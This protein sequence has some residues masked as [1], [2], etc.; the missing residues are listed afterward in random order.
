[1]M[2]AADQKKPEFFI[3][4]PGL[5]RASRPTSSLASGCG[6]SRGDGCSAPPEIGE[7]KEMTHLPRALFATGLKNAHAMEN[8]A[9]SI[10]KPQLRRIEF[11]P[12]VAEKLEEHIRETEGQ[13]ARL[14]GVL[15]ELEEDH[16]MLKDA[17]L[18][19]SGSVAALGHI[20]AE[21]EIVKN[22]MA[23]FAF[24][25]FEIAAYK[26]LITLAEY[27]EL[28]ALATPLRANLE[29]ELAMARWLEDNLPAL[30]TKFAAL[31]QHGA[32]A[33]V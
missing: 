32:N 5:S 27:A 21:D 18:S 15:R 10:M 24:E 1:M 14:E 22:A 7:T 9:I 20:F 4:F 29:E 28:P 8:Q 25:N 17:A 33:K 2:I 19:F 6:T 13:I 16:S 31:Q 23:N 26:S 3:R 11:Y 12:E 30:T